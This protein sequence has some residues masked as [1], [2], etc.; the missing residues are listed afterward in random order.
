MTPNHTSDVI[1]AT[2]PKRQGERCANKTMKEWIRLNAVIVIVGMA[3]YC[4]A[5]CLLVMRMQMDIH[6][7]RE[8]GEVVMRNY[9]GIVLPAQN[10]LALVVVGI[11][12]FFLNRRQSRSWAASRQRNVLIAMPILTLMAIFAMG[13]I[14]D[15]WLSRAIWSFWNIL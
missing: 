2:A 5:S 8:T 1:V 3:A 14:F 11:A 4:A 6:N 12:S 9:N 15:S 10:E 13:L 7:D